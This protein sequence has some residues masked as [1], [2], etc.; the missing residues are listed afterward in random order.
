MDAFIS[1]LLKRRQVAITKPKHKKDDD[2]FDRK[3]KEIQTNL[4]ILMNLLN[5]DMPEKESEAKLVK[6]V[7]RKL[8][9]ESQ[10]SLN[11]IIPARKRNYVSKD[12]LDSRAWN[13]AYRSN[14]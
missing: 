12:I 5:M 1:A 11:I 6:K 10:E 3:L 13:E 8:I 14:D 4:A 2:D 9:Y 7:L